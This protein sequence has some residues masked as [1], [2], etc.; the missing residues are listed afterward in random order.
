MYTPHIRAWAEV[1]FPSP[2]GDAD[3]RKN[4][5]WPPSRPQGGVYTWHKL[6]IVFLPHFLALFGNFGDLAE[7]TVRCRY[8]TEVKSAT[9]TV[10]TPL[11]VTAEVTPRYIP[12]TAFR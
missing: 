7:I 11:G 10:H 5:F 3:V 6:K 9:K 12:N 4:A 2:F 1:R 8:S